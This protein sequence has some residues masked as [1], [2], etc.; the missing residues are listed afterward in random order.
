MAL[1]HVSPRMPVTDRVQG[2]ATVAGVRLV[3]SGA[4]WKPAGSTGIEISYDETARRWVVEYPGDWLFTGS[5]KRAVEFLKATG[6]VPE[7]AKR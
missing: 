5:R 4:G 1:S 6:L 7:E 3:R 2:E